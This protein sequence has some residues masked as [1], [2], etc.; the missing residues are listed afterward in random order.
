MLPRNKNKISYFKNIQIKRFMVTVQKY[1][2]E[3][4]AVVTRF[5]KVSAVKADPV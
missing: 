5:V 1:D 2:A 3:G 4:Q